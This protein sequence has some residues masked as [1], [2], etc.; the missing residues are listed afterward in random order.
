MEEKKRGRGRP[1]RI[2]VEGEENDNLSKISNIKTI[3]DP[4]MDPYY[5]GVDSNCFTLFEHIIPPQGLPYSKSIGFYTNFNS[6][7]EKI[8]K[9]KVNSKDY[10]SIKSYIEE[11]E[12][13]INQVQKLTKITQI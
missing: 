3:S 10:S 12:S 13:I 7:L 8:C 5:V 11:Y 4:L 6:C 2:K 9:F 1:K